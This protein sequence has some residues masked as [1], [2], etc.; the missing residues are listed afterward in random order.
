MMY[1]QCHATCYEA[2]VV[3]VVIFSHFVDITLRMQENMYCLGY[4][5]GLVFKIKR[6]I[7]R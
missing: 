2:C 7:S 1:L 6:A 3:S 5:D 4:I